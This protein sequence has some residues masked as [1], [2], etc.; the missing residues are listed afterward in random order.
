MAVILYNFREHVPSLDADSCL[1]NHNTYHLTQNKAFCYDID[2]SLHLVYIKLK[3]VKEYDICIFQATSE[4]TCLISL[5]SLLVHI[6]EIIN[7][8][9]RYEVCPKSNA[10]DLK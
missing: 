9:G 2:T 3:N 10:S 1:I 6:N 7:Q 8:T 4:A 5:L